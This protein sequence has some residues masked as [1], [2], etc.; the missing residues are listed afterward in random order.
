MDV[1]GCW[2]DIAGERNEEPVQEAGGEGNLEG[3][4]LGEEVAW[5]IYEG[6]Q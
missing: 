5:D 3:E 2:R 4:I 1:E 6:C